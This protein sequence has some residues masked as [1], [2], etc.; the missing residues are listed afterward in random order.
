MFKF[1]LSLFSILILVLTYSLQSQTEKSCKTRLPETI[2]S[3][4][5][6]FLPVINFRGNT[7]FFDR[8]LH[9]DNMD[10][11]K[12]ID[13]IWK[14]EKD[15]DGT[16]TEPINLG[17]NV[18][19]KSSNVLF[20]ITPDGYGLFYGF[21]KIPGFCIA[22]KTL[23]GWSEPQQIKISN[24]SNKSDN[25]FACMSADR[26]II[27][28]ALEGIDSKG[29]LDLY[30]SFRES[31][32]STFSEP[33]NLGML[34]TTGID[35]S[36]YLAYDNKTIYF[37]SNG[38][39]GFGKKDL[40]MTRR[41]DDS[42]TSWSDPINLGKIINTPED[43]SSICL[44][45]VADTAFI[46]SWDTTAKREGIYEVCI[47]D[48]LLPLGYSLVF[49][50]IILADIHGENRSFGSVD[51][52]VTT[53][54]GSK[55]DYYESDPE[56]GEYCIVIP[57]GSF[58]P[59]FFTRKDYQEFGVSVS[60][61][62]QRFPQLVKYDITLTK[63]SLQTS[64]LGTILFD[65]DRFKVSQ[66]NIDEIKKLTDFVPIPQKTK[67]EIIGYTDDK[68]TDEYNINLSRLRAEEVAKVLV[69]LGFD[70]SKMIVTGKGNSSKISDD[71]SKNR[72]VEINL[73]Q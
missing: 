13:D 72:R 10:K 71:P 9:P 69:N 49:G 66:L 30:V 6:S 65:Y 70:S 27:V 57:Y 19:S 23:N 40:Y 38:R 42:W 2:N 53:D 36:P 11:T 55:A 16:W 68:G 39:N 52:K 25:Y 47:P 67:L 17:S 34:N 51:I 46:V 45:S 54:N 44:T 3:Y 50:K 33:K 31:N 21:G 4:Q 60:T 12:D 41:L 1:N 15:M 29:G 24:F 22:R 64:L 58:S 32:T 61:K 73:I 8:K 14:S 5:P 43:E 63:E 7:L 18:N 26:Q 59:I 62:N 37:S 28:F 48:S 35:G 56:T 20:S